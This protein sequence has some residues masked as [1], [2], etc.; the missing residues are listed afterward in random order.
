M[1]GGGL[2]ARRCQRAGGTRTDLAQPGLGGGDK[3]RG[4]DLW[5]HL[6]HCGHWLGSGGMAKGAACACMHPGTPDEDTVCA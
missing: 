5:E 2:Q 3:G 6:V 4:V 1:G